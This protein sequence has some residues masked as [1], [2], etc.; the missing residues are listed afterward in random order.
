M[1]KAASPTGSGLFYYLSHMKK[2][3][4]TT[5][6]IPVTL[7][8]IAQNPADTVRQSSTMRFADSTHGLIRSQWINHGHIMGNTVQ[9][10]RATDVFTGKTL[11]GLLFTD[12]AGYQALVD[13]DE[14]PAL[15]NAMNYIISKV[16]TTK[17]AANQEQYTFRSRSGFEAG[18]FVNNKNQWQLYLQLKWRNPN[19][20]TLLKQLDVEV[21]LEDLKDVINEVQ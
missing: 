9:I 4:F 14:L 10:Y 13:A 3:V 1:P 12:N 16:I 11:T 2:I 17:P 15:L 8:A 19:T 18:C 21:F 5:L 6:L 7:L 20:M